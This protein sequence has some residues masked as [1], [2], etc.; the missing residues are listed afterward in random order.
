MKTL[1]SRILLSLAALLGVAVLGLAGALAW[2]SHQ[3]AR[4][5]D[6]PFPAVAAATAPA[7]V[8]RGA[9][10][11][12]SEC[13]GC[14]AG[15]SGRAAGRVLDD[16]PPFL[17]TIRAAN[18]TRHPIAG[19]GSLTDGQLARAIRNGLLPDGHRALV[20][21]AYPGLSDADLSAILGFLRSDDPLFAPDPAPQARPVPSAA[22]KLIVAF[23]VGAAPERSEPVVAAPLRGPTAEYGRYLADEVL[24][25]HACHTAGFAA[26]KLEGPG[27][28]A[29]GFEL[30]DAHGRP[31][32]TPNITPDPDTGVGRWSRQDLVRALRD[33]V[34]PDGSAIGPP[35]PRFREL[36]DDEL[37]AVATYLSTRPPVRHAVPRP[38]A[39][40]ARPGGQGAA[41]FASRGCTACHGPGAPFQD[42]LRAA[43]GRSLEEVADRILHAERYAPGTQMPTFAG[44]LSPAEARALAGYVRAEVGAR[45]AAE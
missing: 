21:P 41:L 18:L 34:R 30:R 36:G 5:W 3:I 19:V 8:A 42:R 24:H 29:G 43:A 2:A 28:Y 4:T 1:L 26:D 14:H 12:R 22:G 16:L 15:G 40:V 7:A 35:M 9:A 31:L 37:A 20:M 27:A 45:A 11:F 10:L 44:V 25:C 39:E 6:L 13:T 23:A 33:G 17:G 32:L 38:A